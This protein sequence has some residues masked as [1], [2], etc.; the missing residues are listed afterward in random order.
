[1]A[2]FAKS[3]RKYRTLLCV[4]AFFADGYTSNGWELWEYVDDQ[5]L[6]TNVGRPTYEDVKA[7]LKVL[8]TAGI[9]RKTGKYDHRYGAGK[10]KH[11]GTAVWELLDSKALDA[12]IAEEKA[13]WEKAPVDDDIA[14]WVNRTITHKTPV[15]PA[16]WRELV[17]GVKEGEITVF[18]RDPNREIEG[19]DIEEGEIE[20]LDI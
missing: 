10:G 7:V 14:Q 12:F 5:A 17:K 11:W 13:A 18:F 2:H 3:P 8:E 15:P 9:L 16:I 1:M 20:D 4:P 19:E 6:E